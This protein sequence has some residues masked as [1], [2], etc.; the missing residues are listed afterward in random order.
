MDA[1]QALADL[2][3]ISS[4]IESAVLFDE[5]GAVLGSTLSDAGAAKAL[6]EGAA[7][8]LE[9]AAAFRSSEATVTQLEA[10]THDGSVF[11]VRDGTRRIAATTGPAPTVGLVFYD[12]KSCLRDSAPPAE[13]EKPKRKPRTKKADADEA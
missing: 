1:A 11:V 7:Q 12:L 3:E 9:E 13:A 2:T 4:Q 8:L 10:S 6:A 5:Q